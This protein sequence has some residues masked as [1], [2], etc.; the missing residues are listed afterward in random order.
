ML[1]TEYLMLFT[2]YHLLFR[3]ADIREA[4]IYLRN[5]VQVAQILFYSQIYSVLCARK[6]AVAADRHPRP[7][8]REV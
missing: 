1:F 5:T 6:A 4:D 2:E 7:D 8:R 3:E